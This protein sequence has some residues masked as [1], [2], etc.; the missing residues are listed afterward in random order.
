[1]YSASSILIHCCWKW[2]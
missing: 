1:M 2:W